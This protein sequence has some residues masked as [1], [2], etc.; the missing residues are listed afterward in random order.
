[1]TCLVTKLNKEKTTVYL[2]FFSSIQLPEMEIRSLFSHALADF[3]E[4]KKDGVH[5][6]VGELEQFFNWQSSLSR[7][8]RHVFDAHARARANDAINYAQK[9]CAMQMWGITIDAF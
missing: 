4:W 5:V 9:G 6:L 2:L 3:N 1:M 7:Q 8:I